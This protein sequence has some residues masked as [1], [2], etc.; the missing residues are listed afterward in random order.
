MVQQ[1]QNVWNESFESSCF[2]LDIFGQC[3]IMSSSVGW[4]LSNK[5]QGGP[6]LSSNIRDCPKLSNN[7]QNSDSRAKHPENL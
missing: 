3:P 2:L 7:V 5:V 6:I 1:D 4:L